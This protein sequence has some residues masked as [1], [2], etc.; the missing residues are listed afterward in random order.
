MAIHLEVVTSP[1]CPHSPRAVRLAQQVTS[2]MSSVVVEEI[3][4]FTSWGKERAE[5]YGVTATPTFVL[6]GEVVFVGIPE[7]NQLEDIL[8]SALREE[9]E[10]NSYFF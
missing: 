6:G 7:K 8:K 9:R 2:K 1:N 10:K 5:Q 3:N 4:T